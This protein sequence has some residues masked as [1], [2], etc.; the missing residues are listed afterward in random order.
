MDIPLVPGTDHLDWE[1]V[2]RNDLYASA[3]WQ[4]LRS[5]DPSL[6]ELY[7][8]QT[9]GLCPRHGISWGDLGKAIGD[10]KHLQIL[11]LS[12]LGP[13]SLPY[14]I[15]ASWEDMK[16]LFKGIAK[17]RSIQHFF[18]RGGDFF[19][20]RVFTLLTPLLKRNPRKSLT[21][22]KDDAL[23]YNYELEDNEIQ[24]LSSALAKS[25]SV[26]GRTGLYGFQAS[27]LH[28]NTE[29]GGG[30]IRAVSRHNLQTL[31]LQFDV[32]LQW[33]RRRVRIAFGNWL[34]QK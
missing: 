25:S 12:V 10:S 4:K 2:N 17:N 33:A 16:G 31:I 14:G 32:T 20:G 8:G 7:V 5:N 9:H 3:V 22:R 1:Q 34:S 19:E 28:L 18:F 15:R 30:L 23:S 27:G 6:T 13:R 26:W 11:S 21:V 24:G 29:A